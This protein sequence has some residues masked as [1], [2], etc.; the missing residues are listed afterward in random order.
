MIG[1]GENIYIPL[2][3][4]LAFGEK[5]KVQTTTR[6]PIFA[7]NEKSYPIKQ[8]CKFT[9][10]D[11]NG[12]DQYVYNL[13]DIE[14]EQIIVIAESVKENATW[15]PLLTHLETF[16]P[17]TWISLT[18]P[19]KEENK[20]KLHTNELVKTSYSP[21]DITF[22][23]KDL[24][25]VQIEASTETRE[26]SFQHG[27]HY[28]ESLPIE[29]RPTAEYTKIYYQALE[30]SADRRCTISWYFNKTSEKICRHR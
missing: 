20:M 14:A 26:N 18:V 6:S 27:S 11:S 8:K 13:S 16:A 19:Y 2:R 23:L 1:V 12:I 10:P 22:L 21:D 9:L 17:V 4:A 7:K 25:N 24:S 3:F 5:T 29:Y 30:D 15:F 28:A